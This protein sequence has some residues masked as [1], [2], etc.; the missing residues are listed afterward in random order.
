ML[1]PTAF[2]V[3]VMFLPSSR[4]GLE[5]G[6]IVGGQGAIVNS[7]YV[8]QDSSRLAID[9]FG[10]GVKAGEPFT[11][12][13]NAVTDLALIRVLGQSPSN[14]LDNINAKG[15]LFISNPNGILFGKNAQV[16]VGGLVATTLSLDAADFMAGKTSFSNFGNAGSVINQGSLT[17]AQGGYIALLAPEVINEGV[18]SASMGTALMAAG[19][20]VTL[21]FDGGSLL[22]Y[23]I[24]K[25][26]INA[27]VQN[28][29]LIQADGGQVLMGAKAADAITM[30]AVSN[31][32]I[33]RARTVK[34]IAGVIRLSG[35]AAI[36]NIGTLDASG[37]AGKDNA[38][39]GEV[40]LNGRFVALGGNVNAS[41]AVNGGKVNVHA[42]G[43]ISL[44]DHVLASG[45]SGDGGAVRYQAGGQIIETST[46]YTDVSG[47]NGGSVIVS[48]G[49]NGDGG[50]I[51]SGTYLAKGHAGMGGRIDVSGESV[52]L[53]SATLD[54]SGTM[55]GGL[56]RIGG[57]FQGGKTAQ[58]ALAYDQFVSRWGD[59]PVINNA[60]QLFVNDGTQVNVS[61][62]YGAGGTAVLWSNLQ[63]TQ[64]GR[65]N[66]GGATRGG[67][68]EVSSADTLRH[69]GLAG[70]SG[71]ELVLL[72]PKNITVGDGMNIRA[73]NYSALIGKGYSGSADVDIGDLQ[74][75]DTF[76][77]A[78]A[79]NA[80][81][82][83]LAVGASGDDGAGDLA[84][85]SGAVRLFSFA[86]GDFN[87]GSLQATL[88]KGY[89]GGKNIDVAGLEAGDMFGSSVAFNAIGD[90]LAVGAYHDGGFGNIAA[91]SGAVRLFSF[92]DNNFSVGAVEA[93]IGKGYT[94]GK[95]VD[96]GVL[97]VA[98][99]FGAGVALNAAGDRLAVGVYGDDGAANAALNSGAVRLFS[100]TDGNFAGGS[101]QATI[102]SGYSGS[103]DI[104]IANVGA[105]SVALNA[106]GDRLAVGSIG[107]DGFAD[108]ALNSGAVRLFSFA[109]GDYN[110]G[111][112]LATI[113]KGY[114]GGKNIDFTHLD[115]GDSFGI[116]VALNAAGNYLA[117]GA[118][119]DD[120]A[121][122]LFFNSG[123]VHVFKFSDVNF[124]NGIL[125]S[126]LGKGYTGANNTDVANLGNGDMLGYGVALNA[127]GDR[128]AVGANSDDGV[129][130]AL[131]NSGA[132]YLFTAIVDT[133]ASGAD[134]AV[135]PYADIIINRA[136]LESILG[137]GTDVVLQAN[138]DIT[139]LSALNV[140]NVSGDGG[141]L[142][143]QAGRNI[144][145]NASVTTDNGNLTAVAGDPNA[146]AAY[147]D[148]GVA[149]I[150]IGSGVA[151][152]TGTGKAILAAV[153]GNFINNSGS[154]NPI[155]ASQWSVYSN[156]PSLNALGGIAATGKHYNQSYVAG[157]TPA[158]ATSGN[159]LFYSVAPVLSV[160]PNH[161]SV[162]YGNQPTP[163]S[164]S[165]SGFIDGDNAATSG[166]S[167][168]AVFAGAGTNPGAYNIDYV[169]GLLSSLGCTF[170]DNAASVAELV[171]VAQAN[172]PIDVIADSQR[173][174]LERV[175]EK[176]LE[177]NCGGELLIMSS[178]S[179]IF[180]HFI[181]T[182]DE[183]CGLDFT[184]DEIAD[185]GE[186]KPKCKKDKSEPSF[187]KK[188]QKL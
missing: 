163:F 19:N 82:D 188:L 46:S 119:G 17:A 181:N 122:G 146:I 20:K 7:N 134:F 156:A 91:E 116:S 15:Q 21:D 58:N 110:G 22:G 168:T 105:N 187:S 13:Q 184:D 132:A 47:K 75:N 100:F 133:V 31:A 2:A 140:N 77:N 166:I 174:P 143:L 9:A 79:L 141:D 12:Q 83:R 131:N 129:T 67:V 177:I 98:D 84:V 128:L 73:W 3:W 42:N 97:Q 29:Q 137:S 109:D 78:V 26:A 185:D 154:S 130:N 87:G 14:I 88:G 147:R 63:T 153:G 115:A 70:I 170:V 90:R 76:G 41:G 123:A 23:T 32:G 186:V 135:N 51:S 86:D 173:P 28:K 118:V 93:I 108:A 92:S 149:S 61:S 72:D 33:V 167:G 121:S 171:V 144:S 8:R 38:S 66:A 150:S 182:E 120:G 106:A 104:D 52:R 94:G 142:T 114:S 60:E 4:A 36:T 39:G 34:N 180:E 136:E 165:Y 74:N 139:F 62:A 48:S 155:I 56:V 138:N 64:L 161:Q 55:Q 16:N 35:D 53:L 18:I 178:S 124:S 89:V 30:A 54:A 69:A 81:G 125:Q 126:T 162:I 151:L 175:A 49:V 183:T 179:A 6:V 152:N 24:D 113:G 99:W 85:N 157:F 80:A 103:K 65:I 164:A 117:V 176:P 10:F 44:A 95:N 25:G 59:M 11:L 43:D 148:A 40:E 57:A 50:I 112:L 5:G 145:F 127:I 159:W 101:L 160:T 107:D 172:I 1:L 71:A 111:S 158:Y 169:S 96:V 102:G 37:L 27:L 68:V 45:G